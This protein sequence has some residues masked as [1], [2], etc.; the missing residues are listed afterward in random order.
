MVGY[1]D[2]K[3]GYENL[4]EGDASYWWGESDPMIGITGTR[5]MVAGTA[6]ILAGETWQGHDPDSLADFMQTEQGGTD[7]AGIRQGLEDYVEWDNPGTATD[8]S[9]PGPGLYFDALVELDEVAYFGGSFDYDDF[10]A[11][12]DAGRPVLLNLMTYY[13]DWLGH[14]VVGYG[15]RDDMFQIEQAKPGPNPLITVGGFAVW[16]TWSNG[17]G[18][19]SQAEWR[20][21][22][23]RSVYPY[24]DSDGIEWW[25]F[26]DFVGSSFIGYWDWM[27]VEGI[28]MDIAIVP[29]PASIVVWSLLGALGVLAGWHRRP[30]AA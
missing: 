15:Y 7:S 26:V 10:T 12:I 23:G 25:P 20:N 27:I 1:W 28:S 14:S 17:G 18:P 2:G 13:A 29:E 19:G 30:R 9:R 5:S 21:W 16:D 4:F 24:L 11:E 22:V 6:H 8:E 3:A